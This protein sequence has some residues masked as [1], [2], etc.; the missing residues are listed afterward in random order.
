MSE[1]DWHA[2]HPLY[3]VSTQN[4]KQSQKLG[5]KP[6]V[7]P[8]LVIPGRVQGLRFGSMEGAF[9]GRALGKSYQIYSYD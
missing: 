9:E 2:F 4:L 6:F 1:G 7:L 5:Q 8:A 3:T